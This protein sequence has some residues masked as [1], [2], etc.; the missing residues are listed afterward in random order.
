MVLHLCSVWILECKNYKA[1]NTVHLQA[2][3]LGN[4]SKVDN[5]VGCI[6]NGS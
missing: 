6:V 5:I 4:R 3:G 1:R 2:I